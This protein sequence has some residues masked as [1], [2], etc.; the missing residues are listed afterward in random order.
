MVLMGLIEEWLVGLGVGYCLNI[1]QVVDYIFFEA[2]LHP[3]SLLA[4][5]QW[6]SSPTLVYVCW[7]SHISMNDYILMDIH[8]P[9]F[10]DEL[11]V[12]IESGPHKAGKKKVDPGHPGHTGAVY[13]FVL[14][15]NF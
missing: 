14:D 1:G 6:H 5:N 9:G 15:E 4:I 12:M 11:Y 3:G 8:D 13:G 2:S 7:K 10:F